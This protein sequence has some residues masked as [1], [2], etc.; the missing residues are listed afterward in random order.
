MMALS[1]FPRK[2]PR[3]SLDRLRNDAQEAQCRAINTYN[4]T[5]KSFRELESKTVTKQ[6][7]SQF[8]FFSY[9]TKSA[10]KDIAAFVTARD[11]LQTQV[12][13]GTANGRNDL[14]Q[15]DAQLQLRESQKFSEI[16]SREH[17]PTEP[18]IIGMEEKA[19]V[20]ARQFLATPQSP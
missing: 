1:L 16:L 8:S 20:M 9:M 7:S 19:A 13:F 14:D 10:R 4:A 11:F 5:L 17:S 12:D 2:T 6:F 3:Y 18:S 15:L